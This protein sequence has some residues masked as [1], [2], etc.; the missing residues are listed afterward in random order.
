MQNAHRLH[1]ATFSAVVRF[2]RL[3][4]ADW[5]VEPFPARLCFRLAPPPCWRLR[6]PNLDRMASIYLCISLILVD[7]EEE[8]LSTAIN[9]ATAFF[10]QNAASN[11][12][13]AVMSF[14]LVSRLWS[15]ALI[16]ALMSL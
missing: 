3:V 5:L 4:A 2:A 11:S 9:A 6:L 10:G 13:A 15:F 1:S 7:S 12:A 16:C 8:P 14:S